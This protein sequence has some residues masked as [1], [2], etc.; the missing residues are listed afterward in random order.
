V[1]ADAIGDG[2]DGTAAE[3]KGADGG[4]SRGTGTDEGTDDVDETPGGVPPSS[5]NALGL[6][7]K[8]TKTSMATTTRTDVA[9]VVSRAR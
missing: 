1:G 9:R 2:A 3:T 4:D 8:G 7:P 5:D 6:Q